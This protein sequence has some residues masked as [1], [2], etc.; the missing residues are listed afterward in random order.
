QAAQVQRGDRVL[1][2]G[3]GSGYQAAILAEVGV[4][5]F[6]IEI[7][8]ELGERARK[9]LDRTGYQDLKTRVGDGYQGWPEEAPFD[10]IVVTAAPPRVPQPL[11][12]QLKLGGR[13]IIP[14]GQYSQEL[15]AMTR[16]E[17][18]F[19]EQHIAGVRFVPMTGEAQ[20]R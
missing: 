15:F 3:T 11:L 4:H 2:I 8:E 13:L 20:Q 5:V 18:G 16:T 17:S 9:A 19:E 10:A 14:V 12:D 6:S 1:E 7:I